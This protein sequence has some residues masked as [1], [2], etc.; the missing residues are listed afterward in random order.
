MTGRCK[1]NKS[2]ESQVLRLIH[3]RCRELEQEANVQTRPENG[4][5]QAEITL[6][7]KDACNTGTARL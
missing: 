4:N 7:K 3:M 6:V 1:N 5:R 2:T